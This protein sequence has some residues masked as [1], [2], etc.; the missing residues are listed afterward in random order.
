[1]A[2]PCAER[3][4][5]NTQTVTNGPDSARLILV[6]LPFGKGIISELRQ[7]WTI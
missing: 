4:F 3:N 1:V 5:K 6:E 7:R 2:S